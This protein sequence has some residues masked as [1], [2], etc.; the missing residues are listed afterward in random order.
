[1]GECC[2]REDVPQERK[3]INSFR[4]IDNE[5]KF[6]FTIQNYDENYEK[7]RSLSKNSFE[8]L[9]QMQ[10][11]RVNFIQELREEIN[12]NKQNIDSNNYYLGQNLENDYNNNYYVPNMHNLNYYNINEIQRLLYYIIIMT[13]TL[14]SYLK[15]NFASN[16]LEKSLLELSYIILKR[17]YNNKDLKLILYYLSRMFEILFES[18]N[19]QGYL[20][21][22]EYLSK[23]NIVTRDYNILAKDEKYIFLLSIIISLGLCFKKGIYNLIIDN[24]YKS[25]IMSYYIYLILKNYKFIDENYLFYRN[26]LIKNHNINSNIIDN[27][28]TTNNLFDKNDLIEKDKL[29]ENII[30]KSINYKDIC[31]ISN[32]IFYFFILCTQDTYT[33]KNIFYEFDNHL[34]IGLRENKLENEINLSKFKEAIYIVLSC[35]VILSDKCWTMIL[36][37]FEY[38]CESKK[39][40]IND[41]YYEMIINLFHLFNK[42]NNKLFIDKYSSLISRIFIIERETNKQKNL[43]IDRLYD[44]IYNSSNKYNEFQKINDDKTNYENIF[45]F[46]NIIKYISFHFKK[47]KDIKLA[48]DILMY[49]SHFIYKIR[50]LHKNRKINIT[51]YNVNYAQIIEIFNVTLY[52]FDY[53]K[54]DYY[55]NLNEK[56]QI[57][58]S[59]FLSTYIL[60]FN[61][62]F[63]IKGNNLLNKFDCIIIDTI[64]YLEI[65]MIKYNR[66]INL[67]IMINLLFIYISI[68]NEKEA[69]D[70]ED[71]NHNLNNNLE[72]LI[73]ETRMSNGFG[74]FI[75]D[76]Q[77]STFHI[78]IIYCIILLILIEINKKNSK[79]DIVSKHNKIMKNINQYNQFLSSKIF[80]NK[81]N[82]QLFNIKALINELSNVESYTI[83][84]NIFHQIL[85]IIQKDLFNN[86]EENESQNSYNIYRARTLY[87]RDKNSEI[88]INTTSEYNGYYQNRTQIFLNNNDIKDSFSQFSDYSSVHHKHNLYPTPNKSYINLSSNDIFSEKVNM[89]DA[90]NITTNISNLNKTD[91]LSDKGSSIYNFKI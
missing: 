88:N 76:N 27:N 34:D 54:N 35:N 3:I 45:F 19:F 25:M 83:H 57:T 9:G 63:K 37:F 60:M 52:N 90:N 30:K 14:K 47:I 1:M 28:I 80:P 66:K 2:T 23:L 29:S 78:K 79:D 18:N 32:S 24:S 12:A 65:G 42:I 13:I 11:L 77:Y 75:K 5:N 44:Y 74:I 10:Q 26:E 89:P 21:I 51:N 71:M 49:L 58:L 16:D 50:N 8:K 82:I 64:S 70:Y 85:L 69:I 68:L 53:N 56:I 72:L 81:Q 61:E 20:N 86:N 87:K 59:K 7:I 67:Q 48:H 40:G 73:E 55:T 46:I 84:K 41:A 22:N 43:I 17:N 38:I 39:F 15:R 4:N 31:V 6:Y 62:Y 36:A 33:G 91:M